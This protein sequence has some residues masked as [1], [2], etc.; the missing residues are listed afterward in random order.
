VRIDQILP[1]FAAH[2]AIGNHVLQVRKALR[3]AGFSSDIYAAR[4][5]P[6]LKSEGRPYLERRREGGADAE[7]LLFHQS[8]DAPEMAA[9]LAIQAEGGTPLVFDYHNITP[10]AYFARWDPSIAGG[11]R[12]A[13]DQLLELAPHASLA[14]AD[15]A[16]NAAELV[17]A[18]YRNALVSPLLVDLDAFHSEPDSSALRQLRR[19]RRSGGHDWLFV[20]RIAPN[21][22]QH[23]VVAAFAIYRKLYDPKARLALVGGPS[24]FRYLRAVQRLAGALDLGESVEFCYNLDFREL[25]ARYATADALVCMS[26]HEGFCVPILEAMELEVPVVAYRAAA[27]PE[28]VGRAAVLVDDKDPL[29]VAG[30]VA[31]LLGDQSRRLEL[32]Q[33]G[34]KRA[35]ELSLPVNSAR[36]L[37]TLTTWL[38]GADQR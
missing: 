22:C 9:W 36:F 27:V 20:G 2:D 31:A 33:A 15:S 30:E 23:D 1:D 12:R 35:A 6:R 4:I 25:L 17:G 18:G 34:R 5:D 32:T 19:R 26:E 37:D 14:M 3:D 29:T 28:T 16:Y 7:V 8:T 10:A 11:L 13:R 24:S 21:K 38:T